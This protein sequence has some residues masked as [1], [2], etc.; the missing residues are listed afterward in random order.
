[1]GNAMQDKGGN[2][3]SIVVGIVCFFGVHAL[4]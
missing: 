4:L 1:M 3:L 2:W